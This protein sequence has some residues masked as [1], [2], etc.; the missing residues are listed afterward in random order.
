MKLKK[1]FDKDLFVAEIKEEL[2]YL[3]MKLSE[4]AIRSKIPQKRFICLVNNKATFK[5]DEIKAI[6]KVLGMN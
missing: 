6:E 1:D 5:I 4:L 2:K 3:G